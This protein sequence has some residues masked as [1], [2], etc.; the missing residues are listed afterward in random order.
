MSYYFKVCLIVLGL[1]GF[2]SAAGVPSSAEIQNGSLKEELKKKTNPTRVS[3]GAQL[4]VSMSNAA[5]NGPNPSATLR[6]FEFGVFAEAP[7]VP[8]FLYFQPEINYA[9]KGANNGYFGANGN[10]RLNYLEV[11]LL[12]KIKFNIPH[13]RPFAIAGIG[14]G[15]LLGTTTEAGGAIAPSSRLNNIDLSLVFGAG[16]SFP[17][18]DAADGSLLSFSARYTNSMTATDWKGGDWRSRVFSILM[19]VQI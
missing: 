4:G 9:Q 17:I 8:G 11:P 19:G 14:M 10:V 18:S 5:L 3:F 13:V 12:T 1:S 2:S 15:Y 6:G 16:F 7:V